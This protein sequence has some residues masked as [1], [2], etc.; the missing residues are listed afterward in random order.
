MTWR[1]R[2]LLAQAAALLPVAKLA[3]DAIA[4]YGVKRRSS[5]DAADP[6]TEQLARRTARLVAL[7]STALPLHFSCLQR[8]AVLHLLLHQQ[9]IR[10]DLRIGVRR[11]E[12]SFEAHAW[13][14]IAGQPIND[15]PGIANDFLP[16]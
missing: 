11:N 7:A 14:E 16:F 4:R 13:V 12:G 6:R 15:A 1:E 10:A 8:S 2:A 3:G 5:A 9:R